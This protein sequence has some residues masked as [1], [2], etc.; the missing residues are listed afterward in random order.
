MVNRPE[1]EGEITRAAD[2][3]WDNPENQDFLNQYRQETG[4]EYTAGGLVP[5][6][7]LAILQSQVSSATQEHA[8][9]LI[10]QLEYRNLGNRQEQETWETWQS[11][12]YGNGTRPVKIGGQTWAPV[13][14]AHL[15]DEGK[16]ALAAQWLAEDP[17]RQEEFDRYQN[18]RDSYVASHAEFGR[19]EQWRDSVYQMPSLESYRQDLAR[20]NPSAKA[21][22]DTERKKILEKG[23]I[24][25]R[26]LMAQMDQKTTTLE[27][28]E[29]IYG[30]ARTGY[31]KVLPVAV[32]TEGAYDPVQFTETG[33]TSSSTPYPESEIDVED[34]ATRV[35]EAN[36]YLSNYLGE[37]VN[38][39]DPFNPN[40]Q[41]LLDLLPPNLRLTLD[42]IDYVSYVLAAD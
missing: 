13:R 39:L 7:D 16:K 2:L 32:D 4:K 42:E 24:T 36:I 12:R 34:A 33:E 29:A 10:Q 27:A 21:Y 14:I 25:T 41:R 40:P 19:Y 9:L 8:T 5:E 17:S 3:A 30:I 26:E 38:I 20:N 1:R 11:I 23:P 6:R 28:Y 22:F 31:D 37:Q 35:Y 15:D 18:L